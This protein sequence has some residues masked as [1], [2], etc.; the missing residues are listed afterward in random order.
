MSLFKIPI[1]H[2]QGIIQTASNNYPESLAKMYIL[3]PSFI[4]R[5]SW[6]L[7]KNLMEG[8][9][10]NK[11]SFLKSDEFEQLQEL[12]PVDQLE[13][14]FGGTLPNL[15]EYWPPRLTVPADQIIWNNCQ[16]EAGRW[17]PNCNYKVRRNKKIP[18]GVNICQQVSNLSGQHAEGMMNLQKSQSEFSEEAK[19]AMSRSAMNESFKDC[20]NSSQFPKDAG[21]L[22]EHVA[23]ISMYYSAKNLPGG[24]PSVQIVEKQELDEED[25]DLEDDDMNRGGLI[26]PAGAILKMNQRRQIQLEA[27]GDSKNGE[28]FCGICKR[29]EKADEEEEE[30]SPVV[31]ESAP[32]HENGNEQCVLI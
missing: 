14:K 17:D 32:E 15:T 1:G 25:V 8:E 9:T 21:V 23:E 7:V 12:I 20:L 10:A 13:E 31:D 27:H 16:Y 24:E 6:S 29:P 5:T 3:N 19:E 4:L 2:L 22:E 18:E 28:M 26:I 11:I 30:P